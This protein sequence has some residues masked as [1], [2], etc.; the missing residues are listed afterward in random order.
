MSAM[1]VVIGMALLC[2][3]GVAALRPERLHPAQWAPA[4]A[5]ALRAGLLTV[6]VGL[7]LGAAPTLLHAA[8]V[9]ETAAACHRLFGPLAPGGPPTGWASAAA[10]AWLTLRQ[11]N[12]VRAQRL[13][14]N[15]AAPWSRPSSGCS[16]LSSPSRA[17]ARWS[18]VSMRS[19]AILLGRHRG[20]EWPP[21]PR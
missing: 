3:P 16:V 20:A 12:A 9:E 6:R 11:R 15:R 19:T 5:G 1:L 18:I 17:G 4:A 8:G 21:S 13:A 14:F 7:F 10:F 2:L